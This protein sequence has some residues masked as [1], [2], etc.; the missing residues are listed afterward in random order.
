MWGLPVVLGGF[1]A[2]PLL[3]FSRAAKRDAWLVCGIA[4]SLFYVAMNL[5]VPTQW[6]AYSQASRVVSELSA[7]GAPSRALWVALGMIY[8]VLVVAFGCGVWMSGTN[9]RRLRIAGILIAVYGALGFLWPFAPMHMREVTSAGGGTLKDTMHIALGVTTEGIYL[10]ALGFAAA[11]LGRAFRVYSIATFV[12]LFV[13][14][15]PLFRDV[16][17][18]GANLPTPLVGVWERVNIGVFL[19]WMVVLA[20]VLLRRGRAHHRHAPLNAFAQPV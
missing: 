4:S 8:T 20:T 10:L 11:A 7:V 1:A 2:V 5:I 9:N 15:I 13:F 18:V 3:P 6:P 16:P 14:A 12:V 17:R 19:L